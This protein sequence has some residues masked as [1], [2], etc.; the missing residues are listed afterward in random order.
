MRMHIGHLYTSDPD[1][2]MVEA[3]ADLLIIPDESNYTPI[4]WSASGD[5]ALNLWRP[6][7][8]SDYRDYG[9]PVLPPREHERPPR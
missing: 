2:A 6:L 8:P 9:I 5:S 3:Y 7:F 4:D 1:N